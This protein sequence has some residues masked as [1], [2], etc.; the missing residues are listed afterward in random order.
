MATCTPSQDA[1]KLDEL[2]PQ[3]PWENVIIVFCYYLCTLT[4]RSLFHQ[5][6]VVVDHSECLT[7]TC[8]CAFM[9]AVLRV[10]IFLAMFWIRRNRPSMGYYIKRCFGS[11]AKPVYH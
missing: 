1:K 8:C 4:S 11:R 2:W 6:C 9:N 3:N 7:P 10:V 5:R